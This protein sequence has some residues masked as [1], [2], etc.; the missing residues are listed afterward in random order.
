MVTRSTAESPPRAPVLGDQVY[1]TLK[2]MLV[3]QVL[4]PGAR[5]VIDQLTAQ[6][7]VSQTPIREAL[8]RLESERYVTKEALRG[9]SVAPTLDLDAFLKLFET[10][11]ILEPEAAA[12]A[13]QRHSDPDIVS[14]RNAN[15]RL[16]SASVGTTYRQFG[17]H[18]AADAAFHGAVAAATQN[19]FLAESVVRLR[20]QQQHARLYVHRSMPDAALAAPEHELIFDAV[21][22]RDADRA[23][24]AMRS[25]IQR[26]RT[27]MI[28]L[29]S[30]PPPRARRYQGE[31]TYSS[32][33]TGRPQSTEGDPT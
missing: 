22:E 21:A 3:D 26:S 27:S 24:D 18:T 28:Q 13:A 6:I 20:S 11:L 17:L 10:R 30:E 16:R 4:A 1:E 29:L 23:Y 33:P 19:P 31:F 32:R 12:L 7:G 9:Y 25:H 14:M 8:A 2:E 15:R 5:L